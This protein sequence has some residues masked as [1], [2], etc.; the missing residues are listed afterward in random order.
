MKADELRINEN[1]FHEKEEKSF[2]DAELMAMCEFENDNFTNRAIRPQGNFC[3]SCGRTLDKQ[4]ALNMQ[5]Y[6][7]NCLQK[8]P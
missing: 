2:L 8:T 5:I 6:C 1:D 3:V 7:V 4:A